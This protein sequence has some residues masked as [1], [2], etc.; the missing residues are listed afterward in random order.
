MEDPVLMLNVPIKEYQPKCRKVIFQFE[1]LELL[2]T[3]L[4]KLVSR[5]DWT[6]ADQP[7]YYLV[8]FLLGKHPKTRKFC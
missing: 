4:D 7:I 5:E 8:E 3:Y 6:K 2:C 1:Y